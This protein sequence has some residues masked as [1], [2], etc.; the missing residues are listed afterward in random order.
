[1]PASS[2]ASAFRIRALSWSPVS[3]RRRRHQYIA[4]APTELA[5][6]TTV[7]GRASPTPSRG[8]IH[9]EE[10]HS[11][12]LECLT[13]GIDSRIERHLWVTTLTAG[14]TNTTGRR[15]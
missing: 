6:N 13:S 5:I 7:N 4:P 8:S 12:L 2:A 14:N 1:M 11:R 9:S 3:E 10:G 15:A